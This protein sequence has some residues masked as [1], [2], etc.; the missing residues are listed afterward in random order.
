MLRFIL[1]IW[2]CLATNIANATNVGGNIDIDTL[3]TTQGSPYVV[4][5]DLTVRATLA[6]QSGVIVYVQAN[7]TITI[8]SESGP[9]GAG[10]INANNVLFTS[11]RDQAGNSSAAGDWG[12]MRIRGRDTSNLAGSTLRFG[13]GLIIEETDSD[14]TNFKSNQNQGAAIEQGFKAAPKGTGLSATGNAINGILLPSGNSKDGL[15]L[16]LRGIPYVVQGTLSAGPDLIALSPREINVAPG[17]SVPAE[18]R[19]LDPAPVGGLPV[20]LS[21]APTGV[22]TVPAS[23]L[24]PENARSAEFL[25]QGVGGSSTLTATSATLGSATA[26]ILVQVPPSL[27]FTQNPV[28]PLGFVNRGSLFL[29]RAAPPEGLVVTLTSSATSIATV[30]ASINIAPGANSAQFGITTLAL[31]D[32]TLTASAPNYTNDTSAMTVRN[33]SMT[34]STDVNV[35]IGSRNVTL[36]FSDEVPAGGTS[37]TLSS[38]NPA[39]LT[40]PATATAPAGVTS[41]NVLITGVTEGTSTISATS[42]RFGSAT[43]LSTVTNLRTTFVSA[44]TGVPRSRIPSQLAERLSINLTA[45]APNGGVDLAL[46]SSNPALTISR[47]SLNYV[48]G[49]TGA[50]PFEIKSNVPGTFTITATAPNVVTNTLE[51]TVGPQASL[52]MGTTEP[53]YIG[54]NCQ[55]NYGGVGVLFDNLNYTA[56]VPLATSTTTNEPNNIQFFDSGFTNIRGLGLTTTGTISASAPGLISAPARPVQVVNPVVE[57]TGLANERTINSQRDEFRMQLK[58]TQN[59]QFAQAAMLFAPQTINL[60]IVDAMPS[61]VVSGFYETATSPNLI[62]SVTFPA[63]N[64]PIDSLAFVGIPTANGDYKVKATL[65]PV[66][67]ISPNQSVRDYKLK[68][69]VDSYIVGSKNIASQVR[70]ERRIDGVLDTG[71]ALSGTLSSSDTTRLT[72]NFEFTIPQGQSSASIFLVGKLASASPILVNA[73]ANGNSVYGSAPPLSVDVVDPQLT[74]SDFTVP[75]TFGPRNQFRMRLSIPGSAEPDQALVVPQ[76]ISV[77]V[78]NATPANVIDGIYSAAIGGSFVTQLQLPVTSLQTGFLYPGSSAPGSY[79]VQATIAGNGNGPW[80]SSVQTAP[81]IAPVIIMDFSNGGNWF[82]NFSVVNNRGLGLGLKQN[83]R[84]RIDVNTAGPTTVNLTSNPPG[85]LEFDPAQITLS[86]NQAFTE[87]AFTARQLGSAQIVASSVSAQ[88]AMV[89]GLVV[90]QVLAVENRYPDSRRVFLNLNGELTQPANATV[91]LSEIP[92]GS[93]SIS[94]PPILPIGWSGDSY[95]YTNA[96]ADGTFKLQVN[97]SGIGNIPSRRFNNFYNFLNFTTDETVPIKIRLGTQFCSQTGPL[98]PLIAQVE[99]SAIGFVTVDSYLSRLCISGTALGSGLVRFDNLTFDLIEVVPVVFK[100]AQTGV[101]FFRVNTCSPEQVCPD[102]SSTT[103]ITLSVIDSSPS[104]LTVSLAVMQTAI[105]A[106]RN[107]TPDIGFSA[108][109]AGSFK[110]R[111]TIPGHGVFESNSIQAKAP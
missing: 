102:M 93:I 34:W 12:P 96:T 106:G 31:G 60:N 42:T 61:T 45:P 14:L 98:R 15:S 20:T 8:G 10:R 40:V 54:L 33:A 65:G 63:T 53:L 70:I 44:V 6:I 38:S 9:Q 16:F 81:P 76:T 109:M 92:A 28:I 13:R 87:F 58:I 50:L 22:A 110:I 35:P 111:A 79:Q 36:N 101:S 27:N 94:I 18:V 90:Q 62:T 24:I 59:G 56:S 82:N 19:V 89:P 3:W 47:S 64:T 97:I 75:V 52:T 17:V 29:S 2:C 30:P 73:S 83:A 68:F 84:A 1:F 107:S 43:A 91:S 32:F 46:T 55:T 67:T 74:F 41:I 105:S 77:A 100:V 51:V 25:V 69:N 71:P 104:A 23:I 108:N 103:P 99:P 21:M 5:S 88:T 95:Q 4:T 86:N 11:V 80:L 48:A 78:A 72:V 39:V 37:L 49:S 66:D 85:A 57:F 7:R 26:V